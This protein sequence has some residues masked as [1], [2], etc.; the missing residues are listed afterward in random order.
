MSSLRMTS[1]SKS[2]LS[3]EFCLGGAGVFACPALRQAKTP[4]PPKAKYP[5][6][7][8]TGCERQQR[9]VPRLLDR[10]R[11]AALMRRAHARDAPRYD[12][13][14]LRDEAVQQ[15]RVF[16]IDVVDLLDAEPADFLA[17]EILLLLRGDRFVA[18]GRPLRRAARSSSGFR[19]GLFSPIL[20]AHHFL[21]HRRLRRGRSGRSLSMRPLLALLLPL[22][23]TLQRLVDPHRDE[24]DHQVRNTQPALELF[25]R[26]GARAELEQH[27]G[28]L[29]VL[30]YLVRE[31]PLAPFIHFVNG[32]AGVGDHALHLFQERVHFLVRRIRPDDKQLFVNSHSSSVVEPWAR[33]L[34]LVMAFS[35]PSAI[36][37]LTASAAWPSS[38]SNSFSCCRLNGDST[39]SAPL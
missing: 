15:F 24:L 30:V 38:S 11:Q 33:R 28:A 3:Q 26:L 39:K 37:E 8:E 12:L 7:L 5:W 1:I 35:T 34:Y 9:D 25:H 27:V 18:A 36:I 21:C 2:F 23:Q 31:A 32:S 19:H 14:P 20:A 16:I 4:A 13:A 29:A 17:P 10:V 22:L 6:R